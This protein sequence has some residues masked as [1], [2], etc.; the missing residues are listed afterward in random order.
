VFTKGE[1]AAVL[2]NVDDEVTRFFRSVGYTVTW[3]FRGAARWHEI[4]EGDEMLLQI[5]MGPSLADILRDL[6]LLAEGKPGTSASDYGVRGSLENLKKVAVRVDLRANGLDG[7][8]IFEGFKNATKRQADKPCGEFYGGTHCVF[9]LWPRGDHGPDD[10]HLVQRMADAQKVTASESF[11]KCGVKPAQVNDGDD[12]MGPPVCC[13][14]YETDPGKSEADVE[15][16]RMR[17]KWA[18]WLLTKV[19]DLDRLVERS[20]H[21][22]LEGER[23]RWDN[24]RRELAGIVE[25]DALLEKLV[26][27]KEGD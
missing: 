27:Q 11:T 7:G 16:R 12:A 23:R 15:G 2:A 26:G 20:G 13:G 24:V 8:V 9:C 1:V 14:C 6:P 10:L 19:A 17:A 18:A 3:D 21:V 22:A 5:D 4:Y 25:D